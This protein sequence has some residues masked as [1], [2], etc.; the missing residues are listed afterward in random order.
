MHCN[1]AWQRRLQP[2][3][4]PYPLPRFWASEQRAKVELRHF[5]KEHTMNAVRS[6]GPIGWCWLLLVVLTA[7]DQTL[8]AAPPG[9]QQAPRSDEKMQEAVFRLKYIKAED[10]ARVLRTLFGSDGFRI[11]IEPLTNSVLM[12]SDNNRLTKAR[13]VLVEI[14]IPHAAERPAP[15]PPDVQVR[16]FWLVAGKGAKNATELPDELKGLSAELDKEGLDSPRL[17]ARL[18]VTTALGSI[19]EAVSGELTLSGAATPKMDGIGLQLTVSV[20]QP[21][22]R[23]ASSRQVARLRSQM[24]VPPGRPSVLAVTGQGALVVQV[25]PRMAGPRPG[26]GQRP[27]KRFSFEMN[28]KPWKEVF[29]WLSETTGKPI[30]RLYTPTGTFS[31]SG[32]AK[33]T[34]TIPEIIDI[35][36][37]ALLTNSMTQK[38]YLIHRERSFTLVPADEKLDA[39]VPRIDVTQLGERGRTELVSVVIPLR[40]L[41]AA[42]LAPEVKKLVGPFGSVTLLADRLIVQDMA[43]NLQ[44]IWQT[45]QEVDRPKAK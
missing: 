15:P 9:A 2:C 19:F 41:R 31:F 36:N 16:L 25:L 6:P 4:D 11:A 18:S 5:P 29:T 22:Q 26:P 17:G 10:A 28:N 45:I 43:G 20:S 42:D 34:Y 37:E 30:I 3:N 12:A 13:K 8:A 27:A 40:S 23:R 21:G 14:D 38:Y 39:A 33:K 32:P 35:I 44:R 1:A 7:Q 24:T